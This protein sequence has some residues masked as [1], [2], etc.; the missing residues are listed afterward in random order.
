[1]LKFERTEPEDENA[2]VAAATAPVEAAEPPG[3]VPG[4]TG[5]LPAEAVDPDAPAPEQAAVLLRPVE[6]P[7]PTV[8]P[9]P[10][11]LAALAA[12]QEASAD[13]PGQGEAPGS[14]PGRRGRPPGHRR[15]SRRRW[16]VVLL[17]LVAAAAGVGVG[18]TLPHPASVPAGT[19]D[20]PAAPSYDP[21][22]IMSPSLKQMSD[23]FVLDGKGVDYLYTSSADYDPPN[24][25]VRAFR[26]LDHLGP[27]VDAMPTLPPWTAGW[28]WAPDVRHIDGRY[29]M[30]FTAPD[31][32]DVLPTGA[33]AKCIGV[34]VAT[35]PMGPFTPGASP[36]LC[37]TWG[38]VDPRTFVDAQGRLWLY[39]KSD[40]NADTINT[41]PTTIW[42]QR[43]A[44][45]GITLVG[46]RY[47][48]LTSNQQWE[49]ELIEAPAIVRHGDR[50]YIFFSAN[51]SFKPYNGIG[52][53]SCSSPVGPCRVIG[54][55]PLVGTSVLG[56]G[57]GED[58]LWNADGAT[59]LLFSPSGT[60][61]VR[62]LA[63]ARIAF[64]S[65][66]PYV[67]TFDG[68]T[69]GLPPEKP[70]RR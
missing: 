11:E 39:W 40:D 57:P 21:G 16:P 52:V 35:S 68:K 13:T 60:G 54:H 49:N 17:A 37:G 25:P 50:Y 43:L 30:W 59:W 63:V 45:N 32:S 12:P 8:P 64:D 5:D 70:G 20:P 67:A 53:A 18:W 7:A 62:Q 24:I 51:P 47:A 10:V 23:P 22:R 14:R 19:L 65:Q 44:P 61:F 36:A 34:A 58:S 33:P 3:P 6:A 31:P 48:V 42:A 28:T 55:G 15:P 27:M 1:M 2:P 9:E 26:S 29:V 69:P 46:R 56:Q 41:I 66:G 4:W 38:S